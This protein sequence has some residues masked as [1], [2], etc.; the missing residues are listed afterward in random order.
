MRRR[1]ALRIGQ[2]ISV[3]IGTSDAEPNADAKGIDLGF[4]QS[5]GNRGGQRVR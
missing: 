4:G 5:L 2:R 1:Y 3:G